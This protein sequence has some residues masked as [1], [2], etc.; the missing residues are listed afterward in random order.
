MKL[1]AIDVTPNEISFDF[2]VELSAQ[3]TTEEG[4]VTKLL[5]VS[6]SMNKH[7]FVKIL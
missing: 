2:T 6:C 3:K 5:V 1:Y 7:Y 4:A